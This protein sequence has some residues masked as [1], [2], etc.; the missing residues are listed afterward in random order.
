MINHKLGTTEIPAEPGRVPS[1]G[2]QDHDAIFALGVTPIAVRYWF[3]DESDVIYPWAEDEA[4]NADPEILNMPDGINFEGIAA[5]NPDLILGVGSPLIVCQ[6]ARARRGRPPA[7]LRSTRANW[8][9]GSSR[10]GSCLTAPT[11]SG[12]PNT[13]PATRNNCWRCYTSTCS[14]AGS[15]PGSVVASRWSMAS[16]TTRTSGAPWGCPVTSPQTGSVRALR[17]ALRAPTLG[18]FWRV[19]GPRLVATDLD[20]AAGKGH[21]VQGPAE[22]LLMAI[23]GRRGV[24]GELTGPGQPTLATRIET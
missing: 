2:Y 7:Q 8:S 16:S 9:A 24:V 17:F 20:W 13:A 18:A 6:G 23:A 19:R 21:L 1:I 10:A 22:S 4:R 5:L 3:G 15:P 12:R 14:R 11:R